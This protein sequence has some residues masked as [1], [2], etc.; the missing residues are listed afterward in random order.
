M[1]Y[2]DYLHCVVCDTK[3]LYDAE[4]NY[5]AATGENGRLFDIATICKECAKTNSIQVVNHP[6]A[7]RFADFLD[8]TE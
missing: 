2:C 5:E 4:V 3:T 1:A 6:C 8:Q 7:E